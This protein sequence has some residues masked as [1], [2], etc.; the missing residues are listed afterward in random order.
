MAK[1]NKSPRVNEEITAS[2]VRLVGADGSQVG[3]VPVPEAMI[4]AEEAGL[5]LVEV[6]PGSEPPVAKIMDFGK[7]RYDLQKR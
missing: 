4:M 3:I 7:Y 2:E 6:A 1:D 5:D